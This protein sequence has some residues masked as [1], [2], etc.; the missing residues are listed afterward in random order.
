MKRFMQLKPFVIA[1]TLLSLGAAG[2]YGWRVYQKRLKLDPLPAVHV[3]FVD[4]PRIHEEG[5]AFV[6][7]KELIER[8]YKQFHEDIRQQET[9][10]RDEYTKLKNHDLLTP[11]EG[12]VLQDKKEELNRNFNDLDKTIRQHKESLNKDFSKIKENL[13]ETIVAIIK[14]IAKK[15]QLNLVLN[16]KNQSDP[17]VLFGANELDITQ[18]VLNE[19]NKQIPT[20][21]L[22]L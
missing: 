19:L 11:E 6:K 16:A 5:I 20:V 18:D 12:K 1:L 14:T 15:R 10:I 4:L 22:Q 13:E 9:K 17:I 7:F 21:H 3:A 8:Q 2:H